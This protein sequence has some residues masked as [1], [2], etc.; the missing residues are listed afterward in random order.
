MRPLRTALLWA[1]RNEWLAERVPRFRFA[2]AA[3]RRFIPGE[4]L[5]DAL[6]AAGEFDDKHMSSVLTHL[7]ENVN[8]AAA[9][10][11]VV[12]HYMDALDKIG[13]HRLDTHISIKLTQ[14]GLDIDPDLAE[15]N[16]RRIV[17][18]AAAHNAVVWIDMESSDYV[19]GTLALFHS[20]LADHRNVGICL[21]AYLRRTPADL[22]ALLPKTAAIRLV[23][24]AY[25][26]PASIALPHKRDVDAAFLRLSVKLLR[27]AREH[28]DAPSPGLASHDIKLLEQ[29]VRT[30]GTAGVA[31]DLY[32]IQMLYGIRAR[33]QEQM[34]REGHRVRV[35][36][37]YGEAWFPWYVR[38]LAE[39][40]AN[41]VFVVKSLA[42]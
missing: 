24:G 4:D 11:A 34:A 16:V 7:G 22:D 19:E 33:E 37:S 13:A 36:I 1:S 31:K 10:E 20:V 35:L 2:R 6:S 15:R 29:I 25:M 14:L 38:R 18:R 26:E 3:V 12:R 41:L 40:P 8:D 32:E 17:E 5:A 27:A 30:S 21:Q 23:K 39:R 42:S 9:T 28:T